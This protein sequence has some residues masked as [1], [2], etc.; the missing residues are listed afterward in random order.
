MKKISNCLIKTILTFTMIFT[1]GIV[2][3]HAEDETLENTTKYEET[4]KIEEQPTN[5]YVETIGPKEEQPTDEYVETIGSSK[6]EEKSN[7]LLIGLSSGCILLII[8]ALIKE[9]VKN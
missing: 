6:K 1:T 3:V 7:Y 2:N 4:K 9:K 8:G 5:E